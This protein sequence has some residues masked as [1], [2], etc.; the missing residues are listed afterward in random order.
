MSKIRPLHPKPAPKTVPE[1]GR[2]WKHPKKAAEPLKKKSVSVPQVEILT[3]PDWIPRILVSPLA[4]FKMYVLVS[5]IDE[6]VSWLGTA[7][8][9]EGIFR[10]GDVFL[11]DQEV[12]GSHTEIPADGIAQV[13]TEL[14]K[15]EDG[16]EI[17]NAMRFWGHSHNSMGAFASYQDETQMKVFRDNGSDFFIRAILNR[18]G[19][20]NFSVYDW[21]E[22]MA[23]H[24]LPWEEDGPPL[25]AQDMCRQIAKDLR[26]EMR[27]RITYV[28]TY[29]PTLHSPYLNKKYGL[30]GFGGTDIISL[31]GN[32]DDELIEID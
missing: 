2:G 10:I 27:R 32:D 22:G 25:P 11:F 3:A 18:R 8:R 13:V 26:A 28:R 5:S 4:V 1:K 23:Y 17:I 9:E 7:Y 14:L 19:D 29:F 15:R 30:G 31:F 16:I 20:V 21:K 6:E 24:K 12:S